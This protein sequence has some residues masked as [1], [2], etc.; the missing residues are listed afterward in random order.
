MFR[1]RR[2]AHTPAPPDP[3]IPQDPRNAQ[4]DEP[5]SRS[6]DRILR[7][8]PGRRRRYPGPPRARGHGCV[9]GRDP[10][11]GRRGGDR[12]RLGALQAGERRGPRPDGGRGHRHRQCSR[13]DCQEPAQDL[14]HAAR[15]HAGEERRG[16][17]GAASARAGQVREA[18]RGG[19]RGDPLDE[20]RG[21]PR[22]QGDDGPQGPQ[23]DRHCPVARRAR[24]HHPHGGPD[25]R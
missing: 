18:G 10:G 12:D 16:H 2:D 6:Q 24:D 14:R 7:M 9:R 15:P 5:A 4:S 20:S 19:R 11:T 13:Q 23:R 3:R 22:E 8:R 21:N 25:A 1:L 17:R